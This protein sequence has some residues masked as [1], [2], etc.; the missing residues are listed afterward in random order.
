MC[1]TMLCEVAMVE[2][3]GNL[4][5]LAVMEANSSNFFFSKIYFFAYLTL[6]WENCHVWQFLLTKR[7]PK[8]ILAS[9]EL[10]L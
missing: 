5:T 4:W 1:V 6:N 9:A 3:K 8:I 10:K 2:A 7:Q